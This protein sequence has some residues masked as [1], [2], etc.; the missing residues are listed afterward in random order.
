MGAEALR[1]PGNDRQEGHLSGGERGKRLS[2]VEAAGGADSLDVGAVG[3][4]VDVDLQ[5]LGL[6]VVKLELEGP[7]GFDGLGG[8]GPGFRLHH[9]GDLH[10]E[11]RG[12]G[13][14][15]SPSKVLPEG[16]QNRQRVEPLVEEEEAVLREEEGSQEGRRDLVEPDPEPD[17][18]IR[19][20]KD[21][22]QL[23]VVGVDLEGRGRKESVPGQ[24][25][26]GVQQEGKGEK[27]GKDMSKIQSGC[28]GDC[29][30]CN[31]EEA[32]HGNC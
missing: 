11:R 8:E 23:A 31:K 1:R 25:E 2:E 10:G 27:K 3:E 5:K 12:A 20:E 30:N 9:P 4:E 29:M 13:D 21:P 6:R 15:L 22:G 14:G 18:L 28:G 7:E 16:P 17:L 24:G 32:E 19:S 26:E